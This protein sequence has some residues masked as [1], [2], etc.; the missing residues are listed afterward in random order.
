MTQK[1]ILNQFDNVMESEYGKPML[2]LAF[3]GLAVSDILPTP[4]RLLATIQLNN[5]KKEL[6][7]NQISPYSYN[8]RVEETLVTFKAVYYIGVLALMFYVD[9][10]VYKKAKVGAIALGAGTALG[11]IMGKPKKVEEVERVVIDLEAPLNV[12]M[13][14]VNKKAH[15][16]GQ[17]IKFV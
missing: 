11:L 6:D 15:R 2:F 3:A 12:N 5:L 13:D 16:R 1:E 14:G 8:K 9:G 17:F 7:N 10:D 4:S